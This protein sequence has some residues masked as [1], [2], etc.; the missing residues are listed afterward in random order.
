VPLLALVGLVHLRI[1][2]LLLILCRAWG[3]DDGD[4]EDRARLHGQ[5]V[6]LEVRYD[7]V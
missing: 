5:V 2:L 7:D 6:G 4:I 1:Y 3:L